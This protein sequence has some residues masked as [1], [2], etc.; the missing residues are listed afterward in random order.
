MEEVEGG[1]KRH[2]TR[3]VSTPCWD[4]FDAQTPAYKASVIG[5]A[6]VKVAVEAAISLGWEKF[7][8]SDGVF[9]GMKGFGASAPADRLFTEFGITA[10]GVVAAA[11]AAVK[12]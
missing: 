8:G 3:V 9:V 4:L 10:E 1:E 6:P 11:K 7:I 5:T 2:A 12:A